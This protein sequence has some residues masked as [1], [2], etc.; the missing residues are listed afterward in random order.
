MGPVHR[1]EYRVE[2]AA[3][4]EARGRGDV[5]AD[6]LVIGGP[7]RRQFAQR[8][9]LGLDCLGA[10]RVGAAD[11]LGDEAAVAVQIVEVRGPA[12][13]Q[14]VGDAALETAVRPLIEPFSWARPRFLR[15]GSMP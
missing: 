15:E 7:D 4:H 6:R 2:H 5:D 11:D 14:S 10:V 1:P 8:R 13:R 3:Q 9:A 12:Q